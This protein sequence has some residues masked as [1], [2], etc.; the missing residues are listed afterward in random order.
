MPGGDLIPFSADLTDRL[1]LRVTNDTGG[2]FNTA[3]CVLDGDGR[4][5]ADVYT[6]TASGASGTHADITVTTASGRGPYNNYVIGAVTFDGSTRHDIV[7]GVA[8]VTNSTTPANG[9]V[10]TVKVGVWTGLQTAGNPTG[11]VL[12]YSDGVDDPGATTGSPG[13]PGFIGKFAIKNVGAEATVNSLAAFRPRV[14]IYDKTA[15]RAFQYG[16]VT[17]DGPSEKVDGSNQIQPIPCTFANYTAGSPDTID[18]LKN[19]GGGVSSFNVIDVETNTVQASLG[20]LMDGSTRYQVDDGAS[21]LDE[22]LFVLATTARDTS[23]ENALVFNKRHAWIAPDVSGSPGTW[24]QSTVTL[25]Q[26]GQPSGV[27]NPA[28]AALLWFRAL[29]GTLAATKQNPFPMDI[30]CEYALTGEAAWTS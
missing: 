19:D 22:W 9:W 10:T 18:V 28:G 12:D 21:Y 2:G 15:P 11:A 16:Q 27:I 5:L 17:S 4:E 30:Q 24:T 7:P 13:D 1:D 8:L 23:V 20:L 14:K 25:T 26:S 29:I 3:S 6:L